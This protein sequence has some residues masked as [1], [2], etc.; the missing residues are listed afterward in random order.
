MYFYIN[1]SDPGGRFHKHTFIFIY[2]FF[3][4]RYVLDNKTFLGKSDQ[5]YKL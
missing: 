5:H 1:K 4:V 3:R 2:I